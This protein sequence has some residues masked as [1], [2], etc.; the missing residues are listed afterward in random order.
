MAIG[1][2]DAIDRAARLLRVQPE[3]GWH[4]IENTVISAVRATPRSGWPLDV[5]EP[6]PS[7][8]ATGRLQVSD[9]VLGTLVSR[10]LADD[11]SYVV[12]DVD[13]HSND[14]ELTG[15]SVELS[16]RY[17]TDLPAAVER[18]TA[19]CDAVIA[20]VIGARPGVRIDVTVSDVHR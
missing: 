17:L 5:D 3:P 8:A 19:R 16:G 9:L 13:V 11:D 7:P 6:D 1:D 15:V 12:L 10:A 14:A 4:A 20:R 18:V 2:Y